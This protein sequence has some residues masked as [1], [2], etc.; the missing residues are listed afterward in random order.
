MFYEE[1]KK[2]AFELQKTRRERDGVPWDQNKE[3]LVRG[4]LECSPERKY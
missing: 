2:R 1:M 3:K 4:T